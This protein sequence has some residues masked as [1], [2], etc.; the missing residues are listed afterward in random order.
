MVHCPARHDRDPALLLHRLLSGI[1]VEYWG[2]TACSSGGYS[3]GP[4]SFHGGL[5]LRPSDIW[6]A[7]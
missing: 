2:F 1:D 7:L 6:S 4:E 3:S 5:R